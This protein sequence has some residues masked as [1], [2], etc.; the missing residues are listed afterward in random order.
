M[1]IDLEEVQL[2]IGLELSSSDLLCDDWLRDHLYLI[3]TTHEFYN[4]S[5]H[6]CK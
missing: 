2:K 3:L 4:K 1:M 5:C 6:L